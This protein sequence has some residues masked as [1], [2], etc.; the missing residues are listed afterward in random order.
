MITGGRPRYNI[1][2]TVNVN[3]TSGSSKPA[4]HLAWFINGDQVRSPGY[5]TFDAIR[6]VVLK[7]WRTRVRALWGEE[8]GREDL[9]LLFCEITP[10]LLQPK[11]IGRK[12]SSLLFVFTLFSPLLS[13]VYLV[14][15]SGK[16]SL[17]LR[18]G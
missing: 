3:C 17:D 8:P 1:G 11:G 10:A 16:T 12:Q 4:A 2:D 9:R 7:P 5:P 15:L 18:Q 13:F 14:S 6:T